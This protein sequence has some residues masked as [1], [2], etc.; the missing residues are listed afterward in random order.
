[1]TDLPNY[2]GLS[3]ET[4]CWVIFARGNI[5]LCYGPYKGREVGKIVERAV[6]LNTEGRNISTAIRFNPGTTVDWDLIK[7][8]FETDESP[9]E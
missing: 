1:M 9:H 5:A 7:D 3:P 6:G 8:M 4:E 2:T